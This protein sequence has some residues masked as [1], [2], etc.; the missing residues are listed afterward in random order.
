MYRCIICG[1]QITLDDVQLMHNDGKA[2]CLRCYCRE[3]N[4]T[5]EVSKTLQ[6][7]VAQE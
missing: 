1:F 4:S 6:R 7:D 2:V 5:K 3:T